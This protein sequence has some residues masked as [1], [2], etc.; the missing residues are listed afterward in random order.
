MANSKRGSS[1]SQVKT[2]PQKP[3]PDFPLYAH[4]SGR[5]AKKVL[6]QIHYFGPWADPQAA[7][8]LWVERKDDIFAG[9][10]PQK[11]GETRLTVYDACQHYLAFIEQ[12]VERGERS[13]RYW[14]I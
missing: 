3:R 12:K 13:T 6:G 1:S 9:R 8:E 11:K 14:K 5:W 10:K 4:N 7:L 2:K